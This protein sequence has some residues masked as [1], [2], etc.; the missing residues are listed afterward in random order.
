[1]AENPG[2][3]QK[4]WAELNKKWDV[5][6]K[7]GHTLSVSFQLVTDPNDKKRVM[8]IEVQQKID[9]EWVTQ[10]FQKI[11]GEAYGILG[12]QDMSVD[13]LLRAYNK[14][15]QIEGIPKEG[16]AVVS[17][18]RINNTTGEVRGYI[19]SAENSKITSLKRNY[20]DYYILNAIQEQLGVLTGE[21]STGITVMKKRPS[22]I[23]CHLTYE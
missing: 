2:I 6:Q 9:D 5:L 20:Q 3:E 15:A 11:A 1:M 13:G 14:Y 4:E 21:V 12:I 7:S 8:A 18:R 22:G 19:K 10:V 17:M 23:S 16:T